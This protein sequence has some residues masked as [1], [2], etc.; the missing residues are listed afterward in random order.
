MERT[1]LLEPN[2]MPSHSDASFEYVICCDASGECLETTSKTISQFD[3]GRY[4]EWSRL[5]LT[6]RC[7]ELS[8]G[9]LSADH[10]MNFRQPVR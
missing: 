7:S 1:T 2:P 6:N 10:N 3:H 5:R 8:G 9:A 4:R